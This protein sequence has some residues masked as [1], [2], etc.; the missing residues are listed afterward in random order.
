MVNLQSGTLT[1]TAALVLTPAQRNTIFVT[2]LYRDILGRAPDSAGLSYWVNRLLAGATP[3]QVAQGFW[4]SPEHRTLVRRHR[5]PQISYGSALADALQTSQPVAPTGPQTVFVTTLYRD[6]LGRAPDSAG[7]S[8][9]V[10][11]LLA[12]TSQNQVAL[13]IW[14][15]PEHRTLVRRHR[16]PQISFGSALADASQ[17][18]NNA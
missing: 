14:N 10:N 9:W 12:G 18:A 3:S 1:V 16:A 17:A 5:A 6:I 4:Y 7:L 13:A 8:Y 11:H 2:T 15:S